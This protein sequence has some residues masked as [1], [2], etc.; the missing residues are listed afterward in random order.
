MNTLK[1]KQTNP[2]PYGSF[3]LSQKKE[4]SNAYR[5]QLHLLAMLSK[6]GFVR[7]QE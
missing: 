3:Y 7:S 5:S 2:K 6:A 1:N 4:W